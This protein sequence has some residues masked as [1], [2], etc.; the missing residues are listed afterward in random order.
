[1]TA[2]LH[3]FAE[4]A[5]Q[6]R[7]LAEALG[8][9]S[10]EIATRRFP[11]GEALVQVAP[12]PGT[13][14]LF[15]ALD[16]PDA[17]LVELLLAASALR[18]SG[19]ERV[20]LV[21][22]YLAYMRQDIAFAPGQAVSQRVIG[23]LI[24]V[25]FDALVTVDPHLHR[26]PHLSLVAPGIPAINVSAAP[27]IAAALA[28][29]V[30]PDTVL[31]GPDEESLPWVQAVAAP[32]GLHAIVGHKVRHG[33]RDVRIALPEDA[34]LAGRPTLLVDDLI[35]SGGTLLTCAEL[36]RAAG[37]SSVAA[38]ATHCLASDEDLA[39]LSAHG[40][41]PVMATDTVPCASAA[42]A[43]ASALAE[44]IRAAGLL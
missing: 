15:R 27:T 44:A 29:Q 6:A 39:R 16:R 35:S 23:T 36:L 34:D 26:T 3:H 12:Q 9:P 19:A 40:I 5:T 4:G 24:A 42:I 22:P 10:H 33:D 38:V 20:V 41:A 18:D 21:A 14:L 30:A 25:T 7:Q 32:L 17:K 1:M 8:L 2:A 28:G 37:A 43:M 31:V 11:D 13:A